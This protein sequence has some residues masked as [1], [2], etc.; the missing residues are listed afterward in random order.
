[1]NGETNASSPIP[2]GSVIG[3]LGGGQLGRMIALAAAPLGYRCAILTPEAD[4]P[5]SQVSWRTV[6][7]DY[8]D[9]AA[10][11]TFAEL[12]DVV[13]LEFENVPVDA[14]EQLAKTV[15]T[16]PGA[17][18]LAVTQD[19][20]KEKSFCR[21]I[22]LAT[23]D[24]ANVQND[25]LSEMSKTVGFPAI[26]KTRRMGYDGKG[27]RRVANADEAQEAIRALAGPLV[28]EAISPFDVELSV[29]VARSASGEVRTFD[30]VENEHE[31]HI[32]RTTHAPARIDEK[33]RTEAETAARNVAE[34]LDL[35]GLI[36]VEFFWSAEQGLQVNELA[37]RPHNSGHWT[38]EACH[39]SQ[40]EQL[41]RAI[42][43]LPL[44][45]P[46]RR[47]DAVMTN[48]LG[49]ETSAWPAVVANPASHLHLYGKTDAKP[50]RKMGHVTT[51]KPIGGSTDNAA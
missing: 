26:L 48:L 14:I 31:N 19:R 8:D 35:V 33:V 5:A 38:I 6:T 34:A 45:D 10:L 41:V 29:I 50:G 21:K 15:R 17:D 25:D 23:V 16:A 51:L 2:P 7:A 3:I 44:G 27:Q 18:I 9:P 36:A 49:D 12:C 28:A 24:F 30:A 4:S 11:R 22:G 40:F 47:S 39:A 20:L 13:T 42:C 43:G 32:L 46:S 1:M 37:P